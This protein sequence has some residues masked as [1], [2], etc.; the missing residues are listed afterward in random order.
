MKGW[1]HKDSRLLHTG[2]ESFLKFSTPNCCSSNQKETLPET[3]L[4]LRRNEET[5]KGQANFIK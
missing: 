4:I 3:D 1:H 5:F 2:E